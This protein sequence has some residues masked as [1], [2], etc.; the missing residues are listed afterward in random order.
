[1]RGIIALILKSYSQHNQYKSEDLETNDSPSVEKPN[2]NHTSETPQKWRVVFFWGLSML[3]LCIIL[4]WDYLLSGVLSDYSDDGPAH[5][6]DAMLW[7]LL[8]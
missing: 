6:Q 7:Y 3:R 2:T 5:I 1:M 8:M 4:W